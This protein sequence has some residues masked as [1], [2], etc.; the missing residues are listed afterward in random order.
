MFHCDQCDKV[1]TRKDALNRHKISVHG[2]VP[3]GKRKYASEE[4]DDDEEPYSPLKRSN[5]VPD[6]WNP[7]NWNEE[8]EESLQ[9][10]DGVP[11]TTVSKRNL[12]SH[13]APDLGSQHFKFKHPFGMQVAGPTQSG[14]T[15]WT[16]K[17]LKERHQRIDPPV[18]GI[19]FC[20][21]QWQDKYDTLKREVPTT[22][23]HKGIPDMET[24]T[25]LRN[26][27]LV[28]DDLMD[29]AVKDQNIMNMFTV[30]SHH[31]N[32]S[33]IFLMQNIF[34]KGSH[35]RTIS[36]N[37]QYMVLFKNSRDQT[38]I[39]T[40]AMQMFPTDW[41]DFLK[42]YNEET[43]KDYG[44]VILDFHPKTRSHLRI[45]K[46]QEVKDAGNNNITGM[47]L[48]KQQFNL[49]NPYGVELLNLQK[50]MEENRKDTSIS[51]QEKVMK[52]V[53]MM[54]E[55]QT[56]KRKYMTREAGSGR[57][58]PLLTQTMPTIP[59][60]D[61]AASTM[62]EVKKIVEN[63]KKALDGDGDSGSSNANLVKEYHPS[64]DKVAT[65]SVN[66][67]PGIRAEPWDLPLPESDD[68]DGD[69][70]GVD[71]GEDVKDDG[72]DDDKNL[73]PAAKAIKEHWKLYPGPLSYGDTEDEREYKLAWSDH[74]R[75]LPE[76]PID[77]KDT[78]PG[79][80]SYDDTD[81][82]RRK[83]HNYRKKYPK[84]FTLNPPKYTFP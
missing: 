29:A 43:A 62:E 52:N 79:M 18:D 30:G 36:T 78:M 6:N 26:G 82:E 51:E 4:V 5:A 27:I 64:R 24:L 70:G 84:R 60:E 46:G 33:I 65:R 11:V 80:L 39:R 83:K 32:V 40:L 3:S 17:F 34:Q 66:E 55:F 77:E 50:K 68:D 42:Y 28:I 25:N 56:L 74:L 13:Q 41:R 49:M 58:L 16:V 20:Y 67:P 31:R 10:S 15:Q 73:H 69:A 54:N 72:E 57:Q 9:R 37:I 21:S 38:Q 47:D 2:N 63:M 23:F 14:K 75:N 44:H 71:D 48:L 45:V 19:L 81:E 7:G 12:F 1:F 8:E 61:G 59:E 76:P 53:G 22:Q 35:A